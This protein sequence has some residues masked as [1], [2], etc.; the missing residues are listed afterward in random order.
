MLTALT[1]ISRRKLLRAANGFRER[2]ER[3]KDIVIRS[4]TMFDQHLNWDVQAVGADFVVMNPLN[5]FQ[6]SVGSAPQKVLL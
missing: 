2:I 3:I 4:T 5:P 1:S 6:K